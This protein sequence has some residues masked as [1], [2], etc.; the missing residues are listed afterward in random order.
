MEIL[1]KCFTYFLLSLFKIT[2]TMTADQICSN[3]EGY[4]MNVASFVRPD[5]AKFGL[6]INNFAIENITNNVSLQNYVLI[7]RTVA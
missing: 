6:K 1:G 5:V 3:Q 4:A 7:V 2:G